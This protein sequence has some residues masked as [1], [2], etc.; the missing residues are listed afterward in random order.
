MKTISIGIVAL[1]LSV[2][3]CAY[4]DITPPVDV[5][6]IPNDCVN[7]RLIVNYLNQQAQRP[8]QLLESE[9]DYEIHRA[10]IRSRIW[11]VRYHCNLV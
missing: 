6:M 2:S 10:E 3:G 4:H 1:A 9:R 11:N 7:Q 5:R 8:R